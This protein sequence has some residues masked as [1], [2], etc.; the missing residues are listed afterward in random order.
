MEQVQTEDKDV[1]TNDVKSARELVFSVFENWSNRGFKGLDVLR[2]SQDL[3]ENLKRW[4]SPTHDKVNIDSG[5]ISEWLHT[6]GKLYPTI[7]QWLEQQKVDNNAAN[8]KDK[9]STQQ[10]MQNHQTIH[11]GVTM[12][13][14]SPSSAPGGR[15]AGA[16]DSVNKRGLDEGPR[17]QQALGGAPK[18]LV[19][20]APYKQQKPHA[21]S[22]IPSSLSTYSGPHAM[23]LRTHYDVT[24]PPSVMLAGKRAPS[25]SES[26]ES[27]MVTSS[28]SS[29]SMP[30]G[31]GAENGKRE[32]AT[33]ESEAKFHVSA[34]H[35]TVC[36][37]APLDLT[38]SK[39]VDKLFQKV[40][41]HH[42]Q[43]EKE[44]W[45]PSLGDFPGGWTWQM[46]EMSKAHSEN[47][48]VDDDYLESDGDPNEWNG[49][50]RKLFWSDVEQYEMSCARAAEET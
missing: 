5:E 48:F 33:K 10:S 24:S 29:S 2:S 23:P 14:A 32:D 21:Q 18:R 25:S 44:I 20:K 42:R 40:I 38:N 47:T 39:V 36:N 19:G 8:N 26:R 34:G 28:F 41:Q 37:L 31:T 9:E 6:I 1:S 43:L 3:I 7:G 50:S 16:P 45:T 12:L 13:I 4:L 11:R 35:H 49:L 15:V 22:S 30:V 46:V 27:P 17:V